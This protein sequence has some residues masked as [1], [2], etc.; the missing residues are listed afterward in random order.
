LGKILQGL[1][2]TR[3]KQVRQ[4]SHKA[5]LTLD[6]INQ[7]VLLVLKLYDKIESTKVSY[8][9]RSYN[10][11]SWNIYQDVSVDDKCP[12]VS[13]DTYKISFLVHCLKYNVYE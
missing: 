1:R 11:Y 13:K 9:Q 6:I 5:P 4:Y 7:R 8:N 3:V 2:D 12:I 10:Q